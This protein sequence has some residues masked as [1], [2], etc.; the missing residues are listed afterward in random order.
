MKSNTLFDAVSTISGNTFVGMDMVSS[1]KL[2]G[3]KANPHQ[4]RVQKRISGATLQLFQNKTVN[5][6]EAMVKRRLVEEGKSA[7]SFQLGERAWGKR[8]ENTPIVEHTKDD[9]T[10]YYLEG[11]FQN[12]G[13]VEYLL[14][15]APIAAEEIQGL[16]PKAPST[17]QGGLENQVAVRTIDSQNIAELRI[18]GKVYN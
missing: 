14:D 1:V 4:G 2:K 15:G 12:S 6:Y 13:K 3:G 7:D 8:I 16:E 9:E 10:K 11:I 18:N 17:G 5:G